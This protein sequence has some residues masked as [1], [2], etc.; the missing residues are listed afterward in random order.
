MV[1]GS[2]MQYSIALRDF[3]TLVRHALNAFCEISQYSFLAGRIN[4]K[5][6]L[7]NGTARTQSVQQN[8]Q[9]TIFLH[10]LSVLLHSR[11]TK[12]HKHQIVLRDLRVLN[13][14]ARFTELVFTCA[15]SLCGDFAESLRVSVGFPYNHES[16]H[17]RYSYGDLTGTLQRLC[18]HSAESV[19]ILVHRLRG[20][21]TE[22]LERKCTECADIL[23]RICGDSTETAM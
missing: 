5:S 11:S 21:S 4:T 19:Q 10:D 8:S 16:L 14:L 7:Y 20:Y 17:I 18:R 12:Y 6:L 15:Q 13:R 2:S 3:T 22:T 23:Q 9:D 1:L